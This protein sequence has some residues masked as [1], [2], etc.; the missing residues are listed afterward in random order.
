[1]WQ[2]KAVSTPVIKDRLGD[3]NMTDDAWEFTKFE[4]WKIKIT[5][6]KA[7]PC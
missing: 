2:Q 3:V 6:R 7:T 4:E 1:M 5:Y